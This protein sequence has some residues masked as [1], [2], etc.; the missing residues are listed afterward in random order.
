M[1]GRDLKGFAPLFY[2]SKPIGRSVPVQPAIRR[3]AVDDNGVVAKY[4]EEKLDILGV[5]SVDVVLDEGLNF[6]R[7]VVS[8]D[9][10]L[11]LSALEGH[12]ADDNARAQSG[13]E[14]PSVA[15]VVPKV[16]GASGVDRV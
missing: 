3:D 6:T 11:G 13:V 7:R 12:Y 5:E 14:E 8:H 1:L 9:H 4:P 15:R 16:S 10:P 2:V